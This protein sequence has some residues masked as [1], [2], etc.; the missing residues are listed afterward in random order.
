MNIRAGN[1]IV[2]KI[3]VNPPFTSDDFPVH[4]NI[5][6]AKPGHFNIDLAKPGPVR[7]EILYR[8]LK[9]IDINEF[10]NDILNSELTSAPTNTLPELVAQYD[11]VLKEV[12][13]KNSPLRKSIITVRPLTDWY[14]DKCKQSKLRKEETRGYME[15]KTTKE[16]FGS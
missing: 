8:K 5:D 12:L 7:K 6:L 14:N 10:N 13:D 15:D 16:T 3:M 11:T 9:S 2:T 1:A 4:F